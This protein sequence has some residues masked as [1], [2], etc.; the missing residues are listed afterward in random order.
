MADLEKFAFLGLSFE[1]LS[2]SQVSALIGGFGYVIIGDTSGNIRVL[3]VNKGV[4]LSSRLSI[5]EAFQ[6]VD[7]F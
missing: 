3:D 1:E 4:D 2:L 5:K 6:Q 7:G